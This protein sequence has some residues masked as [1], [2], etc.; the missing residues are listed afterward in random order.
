MI[1]LE[2]RMISGL[3][4]FM[5]RLGHLKV[6]CRSACD[7]GGIWHRINRDASERLTTLVEYPH[8]W[9]PELANY[10]NRKRLCVV[11]SNG[12]EEREDSSKKLRY[13]TIVVEVD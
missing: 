10:L 6:L 9:E 13:P 2:A 3:D 7:V 1:P 5:L 11:E 8:E 12:E 4:A